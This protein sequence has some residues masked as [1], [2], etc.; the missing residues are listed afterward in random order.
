M[1]ILH[2]P[3]LCFPDDFNFI[4]SLIFRVREQIQEA[5]DA[6]GGLS[7]ASWFLGGQVKATISCQATPGGVLAE[8]IKKAIGT[9]KD[10]QTRLVLEDGGAPITLGLKKKDPFEKK[11]CKF[12]DP[13]CWI[14]DGKCHKM[15]CIYNITCNTCQEEVDPEIR[16][17]H[18]EPGGTKTSHYIGMTA[19]SLHNRHKSHRDG[20]R[21]GD[22]SNPMTRHDIDAHNGIKQ[23]YTA[24]FLGEERGLLPLAM[25]EALMIEKQ[26]HGTSMNDKM[27]RGKG[28]GIIRIQ[29][30]VT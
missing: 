8:R 4:P 23:E 7:A 13:Q 16:Q 28:T 11:E 12:G 9:A 30:G 26:T 1:K 10:G 27:E 2:N 22:P 15:S 6:K 21:R 20:H 19:T 18:Q 29:A 17:S 14:K 25:K 24:M 5:K 3:S